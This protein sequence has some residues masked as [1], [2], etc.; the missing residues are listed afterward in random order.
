MTLGKTDVFFPDA[1]VDPDSFSLRLGD[2]DTLLTNPEALL[3]PVAE[4]Y[5]AHLAAQ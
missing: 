3:K 4:A 2:H 1:S 5:R